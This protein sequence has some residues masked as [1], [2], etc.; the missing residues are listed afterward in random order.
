MADRERILQDLRGP[1]GDELPALDMKGRILQSLGQQRE[2]STAALVGQ[3]ELGPAGMEAPV[4]RLRVNMADTFQE[5]IAAFKKTFPEGDLSKDPVSNVLLFR[6]DKATPFAKIDADMLERFEPLGDLIDFTANDLGAISG[7]LLAAMRTRGVSLVQLLG[8]LF[9]GGMLGEVAQE[10]VESLEGF[11][12][13]SPGEIAA[14]AALK[15]TFAVGG[16][17]A[18][19]GLEMGVNF[20][21]GAGTIGL[22]PGAVEAMQ[23]AERQGVPQLMP[24]QVSDNPIIKKLAGQA[25]AVLPTVGRRIREQ[26][27]AMASRIS[28]L[29]ERTELPRLGERLSALHERLRSD[30]LSKGRDITIKTKGSEA[31]TAL[32]QGVAEYSE[33]SRLLVNEAYDVARGIE[34]PDFDNTPILNAIDEITEGTSFRTT[35]GGVER[36]EGAIDPKLAAAMDRASRLDVNGPDVVGPNGQIS[37][38]TDGLLAIRSELWDLKTPDPG[39]LFR[40]EHRDAAKMY[41]AITDVV[42]NPVNASAGFVRAWQ[43]ARQMAANRFNTF[44]K[45][46]V[47]RTGKSE[48]PAQLANRLARP[49]EVDNLK[50]LR[51]IV[52]NDKFASLQNFFKSNLMRDPDGITKALGKFDDETLDVL[53]TPAEQTVF[54]EIA[55]GIEKLNAVGIPA[56]LESQSQHGRIIQE[57]VLRSE[58]AQVDGLFRMMTEAGGRQSDVGRS[59]RAALIDQFWTRVTDLPKGQGTEE[60]FRGQLNAFIKEMRAVG[61]TKFLN[62]GD[63]RAMRDLRLIKQFVDVGA[64]AGTSIQASEAVAGLRTLGAAALQTIL[65][66]MGTG[67]LMTGNLGRRLLTGFGRKQKPLTTLKVTSAILA[68][69]ALDAHGEEVP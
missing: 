35:A 42:D 26:N 62:R 44:D 46:I 16:G 47:L 8:R 24:F 48:T 41:K 68:T 36:A 9:A 31:G 34:K 61:A 63:L 25:G 32:T 38:A 18:G 55:G 50:L 65:E 17:V 49:F 30:V 2:G 33:R 28:Q 5:K 64:D 54:R 29:R 52:S 57:A 56:I 21:R 45:M 14:R 53:L 19:K 37:T 43:S 60:V 39:T 23:A 59:I 58:T 12:F 13:E 69:A 67:R 6:P 15:G 66:H 7:E 10:G 3:Q 51:N 27:A 20:L 22:Q 11:Q 40:K 1:G 4:T